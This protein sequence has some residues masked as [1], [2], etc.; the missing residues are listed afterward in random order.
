MMARGMKTRSELG[1]KTRSEVPRKGG[2]G[3]GGCSEYSRANILIFTQK[4]MK[5]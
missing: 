4:D 5:A 2:G 1:T 3:L